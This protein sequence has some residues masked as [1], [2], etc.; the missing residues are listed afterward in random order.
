[1]DDGETSS[2][3]T[4][5]APNR[6][7]YGAWFAR[8]LG[9]DWVEVAPG[10]FQ[11]PAVPTAKPDHDHDHDP[12]PEAES[13]SESLNDVLWPKT[14]EPESPEPTGVPSKRGWWRRP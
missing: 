3:T 7:K 10:I 1:M 5:G 8:E 11:P 9:P 12:E 6:G 2:G 13:E 14:P 4:E